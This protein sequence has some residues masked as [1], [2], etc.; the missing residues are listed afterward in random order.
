M[1]SYSGRDKRYSDL[2]KTSRRSLRSIKPAV[3]SVQA[4]F[5]G[6]RR[7]GREVDHSLLS[8]AEIS[9]EWSCASSAPSRLR[10]AD[11]SA[12]PVGN[13]VVCSACSDTAVRPLALVRTESQQFGFLTGL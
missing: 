3:L 6:L 10:G 13:V 5:R 9:I 7:T 1:G 8:G 11:S 12:V 4:P 2:Q